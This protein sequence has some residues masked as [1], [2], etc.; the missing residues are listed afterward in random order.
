MP[1]G[2]GLKSESSDNPGEGHA[3]IGEAEDRDDRIGHPGLEGMFEAMQRESS[4]RV[5]RRACS[6]IVSASATPARVAWM[7]DFS[8]KTHST[9]PTAR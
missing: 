8:T 5:F 2:S 9:A 7:P 6:G 4:A 3:R 1:S